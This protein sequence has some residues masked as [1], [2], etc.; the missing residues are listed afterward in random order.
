MHQ[1]NA[2]AAIAN[3][4]DQIDSENED[5]VC[6]N[7]GG[8][9]MFLFEVMYAYD[10]VRAVLEG[11]PAIWNLGVGEE[12]EFHQIFERFC[13]NCEDCQQPTENWNFLWMVSTGTGYEDIHVD[14]HNLVYDLNDPTWRIRLA[15]H[16]RIVG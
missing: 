3:A 1:E 6:L 15:T 13:G 5:Q 16:D 11:E 2:N 9:R 7:I 14:E 4:N 10:E 8:R 12:T